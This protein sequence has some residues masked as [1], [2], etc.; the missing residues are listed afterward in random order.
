M[1]IIIG[2]CIGIII[3]F[4]IGFFVAAYF[5]AE[6]ISDEEYNKL[7]NEEDIEGEF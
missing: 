5:G 4:I 7:I 3:G 6:L 1:Q 2:I